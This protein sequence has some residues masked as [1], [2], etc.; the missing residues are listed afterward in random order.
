MKFSILAFPSCWILLLA[1]LAASASAAEDAMEPRLTVELRDGSRI[2]GTAVE[3]NFRFK[4]PLLG[5]VKLAATDIRSVE[6]LSSNSTK[7]ITVNGDT[8]NS[9]FTDTAITLKTGFGKIEVATD[10]IRKLTVSA[11]G[12]SGGAKRPGLVALWS[13]E[14]NGKDSVGNHD[15]EL[16]DIGFAEGKVGRAFSFDG[17]NSVVKIP[18]SDSL[19][20]GAGSGMTICAWI[21]PSDI[22]KNNP[23]FECVQAGVIGGTQFYIYPPHGGAGSL[24]GMFCDTRGMPHY[25]SAAQVLVPDVLQHVALSYD[26]KT[27]VGKI[28]CNGTVVAQQQLGFFTPQTSCD[29]YVGKRPLIGD[30]PETYQFTGVI[31]EASVYNRALSASEI[32]EI[33]TADN[34]GEPL[35]APA[36]RSY[37]KF[38][39]SFGE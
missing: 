39:N 15:A 10:S 21:N 17:N 6:C 34:H 7:V 25:F 23:I 28:Y 8:L 2:V 4:S 24:Y 9:A 35:P 16:T 29:L 32:K 38:G 33:C 27:G 12:V 11:P 14:D 5:V 30:S 13:G 1:V 26:R 19:N 31:D 3:K 36:S 18:A 37:Q 20:V 22:S